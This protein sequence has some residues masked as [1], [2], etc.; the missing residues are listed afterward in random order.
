MNDW[1]LIEDEP[2]VLADRF[3]G[4]Q[5][6]AGPETGGLELGQVTVR[7]SSPGEVAA[8][9]PHFF[10]F[11]PDYSVVLLGLTPHGLGGRAALCHGMR[12]DLDV[13]ERHP[14]R[15][16]RWAANRML[17]EG[18]VESLILIYPRFGGPAIPGMHQ[19]LST[20]LCAQFRKLGPRPLDS[21]FIA[22]GRWW[23]FL[24][25]KP[26]CCPLEGTPINAAASEVAALS[27]YS[28]LVVLPSRAALAESLQPYPTDTVERTRAACVALADERAWARQ[29]AQAEAQA[30]AGAGT[31]AAA[32]ASAAARE[33][34]ESEVEAE[35]AA[36]VAVS[37]AAVLV[38]QREA[39]HDRLPSHGRALHERGT[40][41]ERGAG[42]YERGPAA[43]DRS[44]GRDC[45][46]G[47]E[48]YLDRIARLRA[49][50]PS[51]GLALDWAEVREL[52][53]LADRLGGEIAGPGWQ[54]EDESA[55]RLLLGLTDVRVRDYLA[56]W[57]AT[58][59]AGQAVALAVELARRAV[60]AEQAAAG[61][62]VAAWASWALGW[63]AWA[64]L[65]LERALAAVPDYSL[66][67]LIQ[68]GL[69]RGVGPS[70]VRVASHGT[71][72]RLADMAEEQ[73]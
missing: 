40:A 32:G 43:Y 11:A 9:V 20:L 14:S 7:L 52:W 36:P 30:A 50:D 21:L 41:Y 22:G 59:R 19:R 73:G 31:Q 1:T 66:A 23:S 42:A 5:I 26:D 53:R 35:V 56:T 17:D 13:V 46:A 67:V 28:G 15:F 69:T 25:E 55:A 63:G 33:V 4:F 38:R 27:T 44:T 16:A 47:Y 37:A 8:A 49:I 24:C 2:E 70:L 51:Q 62:S 65:T 10:G 48:P 29:R 18:A 6:A 3:E 34:V 57:C 39:V 64:S 58:E 68:V 61:Y 71:A 12:V 54:L 60:T 45:E 72:K